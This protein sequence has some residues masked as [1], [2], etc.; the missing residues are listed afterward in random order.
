DS[1]SRPERHRSAVTSLKDVRHMHRPPPGQHRHHVES[2][3]QS[4]MVRLAREPEVGCFLDASF[5]FA[6]YR[7]HRVLQG[8]PRLDFDDQHK[9]AA[10][11]YEVDF[12]KPCPVA[13]RKYAIA[14]HHQ[15]GSRQP[16]AAM[17]AQIRLA[18][19]ALKGVSHPAARLAF[20]VPAG[21]GRAPASAVRSFWLPRP[22]R[23]STRLN[24]SHVK[25]SYAV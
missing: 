16:L 14:L 7:L 25:I 4:P 8:S 12:A 6:S 18:P 24:S 21:A 23:K 19:L 2:D 5:R 11:R 1:T 3:R 15:R 13:S 22:D 10:P 17:P 9:V 20:G